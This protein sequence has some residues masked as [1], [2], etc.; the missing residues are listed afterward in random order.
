ML[1]RSWLASSATFLLIAAVPA[2]AQPPGRFGV[3][4]LAGLHPLD[5]ALWGVGPDY[6]AAFRNGGVELTPALGMRAPRNFPLGLRVAA[7]GRGAELPPVAAAEP[8]Q[9]GMQVRYERESCS[10]RYD[11][12]PEGI[13]QSFVFARLPAGDGDLVVRLA[14]TTELPLARAD[15]NGLRFEL[16]DVGGVQIGAVTGIDARGR[17]QPGS[18]T[19][20]GDTIELR[21]PATFVDNAALPLVLDPQIGPVF[22]VLAS[23]FD[24]QN[25][26][27][28]RLHGANESLCVFERQISAT[29]RD[30]RAI[31]L[32]PSGSPAGSLVAI[33]TGT[34]DDRA[35][36]AGSILQ[37]GVY[38][39][40]YERGGDVFARALP[41]GV[42]TGEATVANGADTQQAPDI[43]S[44]AT[45]ADNDCLVVWH[46]SSQTK[47]QAA[48][49]NY[50]AAGSVNVFGQVDLAAALSGTYILGRPR[51]AHDGGD[52][53]RFMVVYP[54]SLIAGSTKARAVVT[55][56]N[57]AILAADAV[58]VATDDQDSVDVDGDGTSWTVVFESEPTEGTGDNRIVG[59]STYWRENGNTLWIGSQNVITDIANVD[60][61][62]PAVGMMDRS[63]AVAWR[64]RAGPGSTNTEVFMKTI[65]NIVCSECEPT[66]LLAN[67]A[68]IETNLAIEATGAEGALVLWEADVSGTGDLFGV[69]WEA[70]DGDTSAYPVGCGGTLAMAGCARVGNLNCYLQLRDVPAATLAPHIVLSALATNLA[71]G[72]CTLMADP[73]GGYVSPQSAAANGTAFYNL[74]IPN[75]SSLSGMSFWLQWIVPTGPSGQCTFLNA[76]FSSALRVTVE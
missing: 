44:E 22:T 19:F 70:R 61:I 48:Q 65:D 16:P 63:A 2:Q 4:R 64:R 15:A 24:Y 49:M 46:N 14:V 41:G 20:G 58:S 28:A 32:Q 72:P 52:T 40:A 47:I 69:A 60:E 57:L 17:Q 3:P 43:G 73:F 10:E 5:G 56:R 1:A 36:A 42:P 45:T 29:D 62:D 51:I 55:D 53:G 13:A 67:T 30:V 54:Q 18:I 50:V 21:L 31:R 33:T 9:H 34:G 39:I 59:V 37:S 75:N 71:C 11:V 8:S 25:P 12:G 7:I 74:Q 68:A 27:L 66:V 76:N 26:D 6:K 35:P 38:M 23:T